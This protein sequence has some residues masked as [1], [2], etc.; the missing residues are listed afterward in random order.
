[1]GTRIVLINDDERILNL[2]VTPIDENHWE[3]FNYAYANCDLE[4]VIH[5]KPDLIVLDFTPPDRG[6]GW[7]FL[8]LL[9]MDDLTAKIPVLITTGILH[10]SADLQDYLLTRF[11]NVAHTSISPAALVI[12]INQTLQL[13]RQA[14]SLYF[15][16]R[17]LPILLV[18][19]SEDIRDN[20]TTVLRLEGY[21]VVT[22]NNG[23]EALDRVSRADFCLILL[24]IDTPVMNGY[25]FLSAYNRQLRPHTPVIITSSRHDIWSHTFPLFVVGVLLKPFTLVR[26]LKAVE[27]YAEPV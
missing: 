16:G 26:L 10:F 20:L 3:V 27:K 2:F 4:K 18:E 1:M 11:I 13:A 23:Q 8:Q 25:E 7:E 21:H 5:H 15:G 14:D 6:K 9:K 19:D 17:T 24:D 22:A 12:L